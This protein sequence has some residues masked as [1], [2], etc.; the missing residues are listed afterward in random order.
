M[1]A[2]ALTAIGCK[3]QKAP[4]PTTGEVPVIDTLLADWDDTS[5]PMPMSVS[6]VFDDNYETIGHTLL[7]VFGGEDDSLLY[8]PIAPTYHL[9]MGAGT[10]TQISYSGPQT[11]GKE[12]GSLIGGKYAYCM[13]GLNY[14]DSG[15]ASEG[16]AFN[17]KFLQTHEVL[18]LKYPENAA[19]R[20]LLDTLSARYGNEV[21]SSYTCA[22]SLDEKFTLYSIQME[23]KDGR[24]L[25]MRVINADGTIYVHEE[26]CEDYNT[27][28]AWH[29]DDGGEYYPFMPHAVTR[30]AKGY[31][32]FYYEGAPESSTYSVLLLRDG[33]SHNFDLA[34]YYHYVDYTPSPDPVALPAD[35][36][37]KAE[38]D[39]YK[40]WIRTDVAPTEDDPAGQYSVYYSC[41]ESQDVYLAVT[42]HYNTSVNADDFV[43]H[44]KVQTAQ[45]AFIVKHP[46]YDYY[47]LILQGC[48]DLRNVLSYFCPLPITT[49]EP[50]FRW[51]HTNSGFLG[52][53]STGKLLK[54]ANYDYHQ[55][56][57]RFTICRY[58]DFDFSL[59]KEEPIE[60]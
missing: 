23:P 13:K 38:L 46:D 59:V 1:L 25:G 39:G 12:W 30:S 34:C 45:E 11:R 31:D 52:L 18:E 51:V 58:Y 47:Y 53:D 42:S 43:S 8:T 5:V 16:F 36:E 49:I 35:A 6:L 32:I 54:F 37:L 57:G 55:E 50:Y 28:S 7:H 44:T 17:D 20:Y 21:K 4:Y 27:E 29:V 26:W 14:N 24:C 9:L 33:T 10:K 19:P 2:L 40:V 60:E 3:D 22:T 48:P 41:P 56:G 15:E